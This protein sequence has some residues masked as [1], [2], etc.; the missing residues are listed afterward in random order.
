M[1]SE[2]CIRDS[3]QP[4]GPTEIFLDG[5]TFDVRKHRDKLAPGVQDTSKLRHGKGALVAAW[6]QLAWVLACREIRR[7]PAYVDVRR[8]RRTDPDS[9]A[10]S[11]FNVCMEQLY[12]WLFMEHTDVQQGGMS[13]NDA[14]L[15][16]LCSQ[17]SIF[18]RGRGRATEQERGRS[19]ADIRSSLHDSVYDQAD[20]RW[21]WEHAVQAW[22]DGWLVDVVPDRAALHAGAAPCEPLAFTSLDPKAVEDFGRGVV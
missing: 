12:H 20:R 1:G 3:A 10:P 13:K 22:R 14:K 8:C 5:V 2:M 19:K 6:W 16:E 9:S 7:H 18:E 15:R 4:V 11:F 21:I 17:L